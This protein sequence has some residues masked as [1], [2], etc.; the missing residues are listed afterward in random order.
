MNFHLTTGDAQ[1]ILLLIVVLTVLSIV[2]IGAV[3]AFKINRD[4]LEKNSAAMQVRV[5]D[6]WETG[7]NVKLR[8][9]ALEILRGGVREQSDLTSVCN[10]TAGATWWT[11]VRIAE[12]QQSFIDAGLSDQL[13]RQ[14]TSGSAIRRGLS[15]YI[16]GFPCW[17]VDPT[18][19]EKFT[20]DKE[21][22]VRLA[23]VG[24]L[25]RMATP[26]AADAL[27][28]ALEQS[29]LPRARII[30]RLGHSWAV[31]SLLRA[32]DKPG[33]TWEIRCD[34]LRA[35]SYAADIRAIPAA[36]AAGAGDNKF[37]RMQ[38]M[39]VLS[40]TYVRATPEQQQRMEALAIDAA[41]DDH[42]NVRS[43]AIEVLRQIPNVVEFDKLETL[44]G[45]ADWFVR[46]GAARALLGLGAEGRKRLQRVAE[47]N[48]RF[49]AQRAREE[50]AMHAAF[51]SYQQAGA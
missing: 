7:D 26:G 31:D 48:D 5:L 9:V 23:A 35:L 14:L 1:L 12:V 45:D 21:P 16:A 27:I 51:P 15:V 40:A 43:T 36:L 34:L 30:E 20:Q 4:N 17:H 47:G 29:H 41:S 3:I 10:R 32:M 28:L 37:E 2:L 33:Q 50:L 8:A 11:P 39:R 18:I 25:E 49:A 24:A 42:A 22:T 46:R 44:V 38:A 6:A 13:Q 19:I